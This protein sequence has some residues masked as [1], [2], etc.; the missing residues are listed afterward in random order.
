MDM[1]DCATLRKA[2]TI[3]SFIMTPILFDLESS[4][5]TSVFPLTVMRPRPVRYASK[6]LEKTIKCQCTIHTISLRT[7]LV[8]T[9]KRGYNEVELEICI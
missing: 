4:S 6:I 7:T 3:T 8:K 2:K 9:N 1:Y 5:S